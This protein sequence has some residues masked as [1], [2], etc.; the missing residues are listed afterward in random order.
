MC[1]FV[2]ALRCCHPEVHS[3]TCVGMH[4]KAKAIEIVIEDAKAANSGGSRGKIFSTKNG[5]NHFM[6][7]FR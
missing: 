7:W 5:H 6:E 1:E 2:E 4:Q 3:R